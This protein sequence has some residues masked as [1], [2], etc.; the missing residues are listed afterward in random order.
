MSG[1]NLTDWKMTNKVIGV[2][3]MTDWKPTDKRLTVKFCV[4][5]VY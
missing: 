3:K 4:I 1:W 2:M 5:R